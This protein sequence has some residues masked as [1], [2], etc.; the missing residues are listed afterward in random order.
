MCTQLVR[1]FRTEPT[2]DWI[3]TMPSTTRIW[4]SSPRNTFFSNT[5][6]LGG[7]QS[8]TQ[9]EKCEALEMNEFIVTFLKNFCGALVKQLVGYQP[10]VDEGSL[11]AEENFGKLTFSAFAL[12]RELR[13][14]I[15]F[16]LPHLRLTLETS[17]FSWRFN[18][19]Y[20]LI[21]DNQQILKPG[22]I[23]GV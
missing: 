20:E 22:E 13:L 19:L 5:S 15:T 12:S 8:I 2:T 3:L 10:Q 4:C 11:I 18:C 14:L 7:Q 9:T 17:G 21:S 6:A 1:L 23:Y 16:Y